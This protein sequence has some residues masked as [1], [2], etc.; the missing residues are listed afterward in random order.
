MRKLVG[1]LFDD[2]GC[3]CARYNLDRVGAFLAKCAEVI[4]PKRVEE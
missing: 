3:F 2:F 1:D 4:D